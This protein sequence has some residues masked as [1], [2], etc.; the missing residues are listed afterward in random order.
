MF[1]AFKSPIDHIVLPERFTFPFYYEPHALAELAAKELQE[2]IEQTDFGYHFGLVEG[3]AEVGKMFGVLVVQ[4]KEGALGYLSAFSG[5]IGDTNYHPGFVPP[6]FDVFSKGGQFEIGATEVTAINARIKA[7]EESE[8]LATLTNDQQQTEWQAK[9][10]LAAAKQ[11]LQEEKKERD[12]KRRDG[13]ANLSKENYE[14][15]AKQLGLESKWSNIRLK[16]LRAQW[17][18]R[19]AEKKLAVVK[20]RQGIN[21]LKEQRKNISSALQDYL[22]RQ[23]KFLNQN[24]EIKHL[25]DIFNDTPPI[26]GSGEC[27]APKLLQYAFEQELKPITM[28]EFWWGLSPKSEV[29]KHL[30]YYPACRG[31]CR[32]ILGHMLKG[33]PMDE[34]P[35]LENQA[36]GKTLPIIYED[37]FLLII[38]KP[39]GFLSVPGKNVEDSVQFRMQVKY[40]DATGPLVVHRLDMSTSGL[41]V[42]AKTKE[43]HQYLQYQFIKRI[44]K[45]RYHAVLDGIVSAD[46]GAI[47]LPLRV[48]LEDRPRQLVCYEYGKKATTDFKVIKRTEKQ[49]YIHFFPKTGRT[50]QLRVHAAHSQGLNCPITGDILYGSKA[51]RLHLHAEFLSFMHPE[52]KEWMEFEVVA[53]FA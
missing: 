12:Q 6:V 20:Y 2:H 47:H 1:T 34:N 27:A 50:H 38:N 9:E 49:T 15:L 13:K 30:H 46:E 43:S 39:H 32:P 41:M 29:R 44:V 53:P 7:M 31:K 10:E 23:F 33:I 45:K 11:R 17:K 14:Q 40:P 48:D 51:E 36:L 52:S 8:E 24:G 42:I 22:F 4:N 5:K 3:R 35:M 21:A 37:D 26:A 25:L 16:R 19:N 28:A 18:K